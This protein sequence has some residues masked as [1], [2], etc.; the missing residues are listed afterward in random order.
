MSDGTRSPEEWRPVVG[1]GGWYDVSSHGNVR[2]WH[3]NKWGRR[4]TPKPLAQAIHKDGRRQV[5]LRLPGEKGVNRK[6]HTLVA[7]AFIG[8]R[9]TG[10]DVCHDDGDAS[11]NHV[12]NLRYD[13]H[14]A[15]LGDAIEHGT[16]PKGTRNGMNVLTPAAVLSILEDVDSGKLLQREIAAHHGISRNAVSSIANGYTWSWLTGRTEGGR[17]RGLDP[18]L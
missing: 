18:V 5:F 14:R 17:V 12:S 11:N 16:T 8:P 1:L 15:N 9:P 2:S 3:L 7:E 13:T 4:D 6:V 10:L